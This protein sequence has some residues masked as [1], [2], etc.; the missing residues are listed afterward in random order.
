MHGIDTGDTSLRESALASVVGDSSLVWSES[1]SVGDSSSL[2]VGRGMGTLG[3]VL[4]CCL[5]CSW[6]KDILLYVI[7]SLGLRV[8]VDVVEA[9]LELSLSE[10]LDLMEGLLVGSDSVDVE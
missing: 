8:L 9:A 3:S 5:P 10:S 6:F 2:L 1:E 7:G 4:I